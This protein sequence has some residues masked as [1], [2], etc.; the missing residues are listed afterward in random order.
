MFIATNPNISPTTLFMLHFI[1]VF[2][3]SKHVTQRE[4]ERVIVCV[5]LS[6]TEIVSEHNFDENYKGLDGS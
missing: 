2:Y 1:Q 3:S 4:R 6:H 5:S